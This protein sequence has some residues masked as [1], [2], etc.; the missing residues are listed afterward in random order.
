MF[1]NSQ[2][3]NHV[4]IWG[5]ALL[6]HKFI[7]I[8]PLIFKTKLAKLVISR[9][10]YESHYDQIILDESPLCYLPLTN[11]FQCILDYVVLSSPQF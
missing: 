5:L 7:L 4:T 6:I 10:I 2:K 1:Q 9:K 3:I 8:S 11:S